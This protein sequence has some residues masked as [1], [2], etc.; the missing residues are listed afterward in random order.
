[1]DIN[2]VLLMSLT[3]PI[4]L[5]G[6]RQIEISLTKGIIMAFPTS[7]LRFL[8]NLEIIVHFSDS[9]D[10]SENSKKSDNE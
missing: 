1:M 8:F 5:F 3:F 9:F 7:F 4:R 6:G 2:K 10:F